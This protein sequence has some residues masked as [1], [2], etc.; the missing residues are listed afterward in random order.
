MHRLLLRKI[1]CTQ[2]NSLSRNLLNQ[3]NHKNDVLV[4]KMQLNN[5]AT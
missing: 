2:N 5:S 1:Y 4:Y 3:L